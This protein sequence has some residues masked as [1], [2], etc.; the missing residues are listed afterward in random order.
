MSVNQTIIFLKSETDSIMWHIWDVGIKQI[1]CWLVIKCGW[2]WGP[3]LPCFDFDVEVD[4]N[5]IMNHIMIWPSIYWFL[6]IG[7][8][9]KY[10]SQFYVT[11]LLSLY[12]IKRQREFWSLNTYIYV[13]FIFSSFLGDVVLINL[14]ITSKE[15][16]SNP[17]LKWTNQF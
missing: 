17:E 13:D 11:F 3:P 2:L 15:T 8:D 6:L 9:I 7:L 4:V 5:H 12:N 16:N 1:L 10:C 14:G